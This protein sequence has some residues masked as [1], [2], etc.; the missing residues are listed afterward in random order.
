MKQ[1]ASGV[2]ILSFISAFSVGSI[3]WGQVVQWERGDVHGSGC[4]MGDTSIFIFGDQ[5]SYTFSTLEINLSSAGGPKVSNKFC[6]FTAE[7]RIKPGNYVAEFQQVLSYGGIKSRFGSQGSIMTFS[8]FFGHVIK[9]FRVTFK[10]GED[11]NQ[12][13][14]TET[15]SDRNTNVSKPGWWCKVDRVPKGQLRGRLDV[16]GLLIPPT[17]GSI[18]ISAQTIDI[19]YAATISWAPCR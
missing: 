2:R 18:A 17:A 13:I 15:L 16:Q 3:A 9:P 5:I 6:N 10:N 1:L 12:P 14:V 19:K 7:A 11:F 8:Q 4:S